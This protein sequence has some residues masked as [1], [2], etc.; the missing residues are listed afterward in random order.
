MLKIE[1][2]Y[3]DA[4]YNGADG[5]EYA[6]TG[7]YDIIILDIMLGAVD[8]LQVLRE[9]RKKGISS[10][11]LMLTA[12]SQIEDKVSGLDSGADD[13]LTKPFITK[14]LLARLR[15]LSRRKTAE[16]CGDSYS[17]SDII[18]D[19]A[20]H[21]L[22]CNKQHVMLSKKEYDILEML[23]MNKGQLISKEHFVSKIWGLD[24]DIEYNS[25][26][27]YISFL[28]KKLS[29]INSSVQIVTSRG[30]GYALKEHTDGNSN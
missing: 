6:L 19:K 23:L 30:L 16:Y 3:T 1:G 27:V 25:I 17:Y 24:S 5:L 2:Y 29:A 11:V 7:I 20:T 8:G 4:V 10:A 12:R 18:I 26:E 13:Y 14:E 21:E 22:R 9:I 15:A 28:R